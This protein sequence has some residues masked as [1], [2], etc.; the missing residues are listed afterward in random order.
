[1][2]VGRGAGAIVV[3]LGVVCW[4]LVATSSW[5]DRREEVSISPLDFD[6]L[7]VL[8]WLHQGTVCADSSGG[9]A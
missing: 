3:V 4:W 7:V 5:I 8:R 6:E 9:K 2:G 1:V